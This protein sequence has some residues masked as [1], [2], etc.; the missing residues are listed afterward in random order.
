MQ[1]QRGPG[2]P[3]PRWFCCNP[4]IIP[5]MLPVD[6]LIPKL[7]HE[8][9][10]HG[11]AVL[12]AAPGAGK[13][14]RVPPALLAS[15]WL[16]GQRILMLEPR[17]IAARAIAARIAEQ[18]GEP[19]GEQVGYQIRNQH[20]FS[21]RTRLLIITE[22][23][24]TRMLQ[25]DPT[26]DGVGL[27]IFD[28]FHERSLVGDTGLALALGSRELL[29]ED[30][31]ILVMSATIDPVAVAGLLGNAPVI[32]VPGRLFPIETRYR[33]FRPEVRIEARVATA[34]REVLATEPGSV[35]AFLPG[36]A[37][38]QRTAGLL[39]DLPAGTQVHQLYGTLSP[40]AQEEA[41]R[42]APVGRRKVVL[43][44]N[45]AETS[46]TISGIRVVVD[47]GWVRQARFSPQTGMNRLTT[48]R[49]SLASAEQRRGRAGRVE[50]GVC[51][52][53]WSA[54]EQ[55]SLLA[56][57]RPEIMDADLAPLALDL[58]MA[59]FPDPAAL[60]WLDQ[61]PQ[62]A[63]SQGRELLT[64][65]GALNPDGS[66]SRHG[67]EM[68]SLGAHPRYAHLLLEARK[69]GQATL[70]QA[71]DLV[72]ILEERD[73]LQAVGGPPPVD[74][75]LR[76]E[77][78]ERQSGSIPAGTSAGLDH[79]ALQQ[80]RRSAAE[81]RKRVGAI[82]SVDL[83]EAE[84]VGLLLALAFPDRVAMQ[85]GGTGR[86]LL[87]NGRGIRLDPADPLAHSEWLVAAVL[88]DSGR[89]A[90][91]RLAAPVEIEAILQHAAEQVD[92]SEQLS[93]DSESLAVT[94]RRITRLGALVIHDRRLPVQADDESLQLLLLGISNQGLQILPWSEGALHLRARL[95]FLHQLDPEWPAQDEPRLLQELEQWLAPFLAGVIR[96]NAVSP[97]L[98]EQALLHR[99]PSTLLGQLDQLAPE[100]IAL[101]NGHQVR[102]DYTDPAQPVLAARL[103][104]FF[105]MTN[106]PV[107]GGGRVPLMLHL[108]SP[109]R[110]PVQIT[111]DL[112]SFWAKGY[113]EVRKDLRGRYPRHRWPEDPRKP[114][115]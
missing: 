20:S 100:R 24:L 12:T 41:I 37:E 78:L 67:R 89:E 32:E 46:L 68:A 34:V 69:L 70:V 106:T 73:F 81:W 101:P 86:F 93:W 66:L 64:L 105:G 107:I 95:Q 7:S 74:L 23:I 62:A 110:R 49:I 82:G 115:E 51:V 55:A 18:I 44:T 6:P 52:R 39:S 36:A 102:I 60:R 43:A 15:P 13:S 38:I 1:L 99:L 96:L 35:L 45:L 17:R 54:A 92:E 65:L 109:A 111:R 83:R 63:Y 103:Q 108:L 42:S 22:G 28:E 27:V 91:V 48:Q 76:L 71:A 31:R 112:A 30:L 77:M 61:P 98:L 58:A 16:L 33:P 26:L 2:Q 40:A 88:D 59:G 50:P 85:R 21:P 87:R 114:G 11:V 25:D 19:I 14:T 3:G 84:E 5:L 53:C 79:G 94:R 80:V 113:A 56:Q 57:T 104:E 47:G 72:A 29:R 4:D 90:R 75:R 10:Q 8:L 9:E 97:Q